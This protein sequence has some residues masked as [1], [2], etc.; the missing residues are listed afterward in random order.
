[1][2]TGIIILNYND[3]ENT[4]KM[5]EQIKD[6]KCLN[7]IVIVD[8]CSKDESIIKLKPYENK[9]VILLKSKEN[10][11]YAHGNNI[12]LKYL[13]KETDCELAIISNP[14]IHVEESVIIEL[15]Q[16]LKKNPDISFLGPKILEM[17]RISKGWKTPDFLADFISNINYFSRYSK[18]LLKY[19]EEHYK[20]KLTQV[21]VI[22]GC[23]FLARLK[24]FKKIKY[25]DEN[26]FLYYEEN[27]IGKKAK[28]KRLKVYVNTSVS[29]LH[30]LSKTVNKTLKKIAKYKILKKS[31]FYYEKE[32]NHLNFIGMFL[33]KIT[34]YISL[35]ISYLTFWV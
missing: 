22:H 24:D 35:A 5:I 1:M 3:Y 16:D 7:K 14:D 32:Y 30:D 4:I 12:G 25:F 17:G 18:N 21:E 23:F 29:V 11:G 2:K 31:M 34:Y 13:E 27:I 6:Y 10:L 15:I 19:K 33:L 20:T 8:N 9:K 28:E 26:T